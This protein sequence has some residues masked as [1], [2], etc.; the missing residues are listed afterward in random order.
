MSA[1]E[2]V[3]RSL[4]GVKDVLRVTAAVSGTSI[5]ND[6]NNNN[7]SNRSNDNSNNYND[8][9]NNNNNNNKSNNKNNN[10]S[11]N[12][13]ITS[14]EFSNLDDVSPEFR[15][16]QEIVNR[17]HTKITEI[18]EKKKKSN[19]VSDDNM[20]V[21]INQEKNVIR[22]T[23]TESKKSMEFEKES[24][25]KTRKEDQK[26]EIENIEVLKLFKI[27]VSKYRDEN[28]SSSFSRIFTVLHINQLSFLLLNGW[29]SLFS[30]LKYANNSNNIYFSTNAI[31]ANFYHDNTR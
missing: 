30:Q 13:V 4:C 9:S 11:N 2:E 16:F 8:S 14:F 1:E 31:L 15:Y 21:N 7:N 27:S 10:N 29:Q 20:E 23:R 28:S 12:D 24:K 5:N 22:N 6:N 19:S 25:M 18:Y 3:L 26:N 17:N